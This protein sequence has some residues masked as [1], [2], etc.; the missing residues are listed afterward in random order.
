MDFTGTGKRLAAN[1][2]GDAA[3]LL[4]VETA[5]LLAFL[6]VEAAGRGFDN[7]ARPKMLRETHIFYRELGAGA[8]RDRAV[9]LGLATKSWTRNYT[10]DSYPDLARMMAIDT[11]AALRSCSWGL[12]Q[13]M[14]FNHAAAGFSTVE[15]MVEAM[16]QGEREQ[17]LAF[18][19]LLRA[20]K[21]AP[22][23]TGK[24]FTKPDSWKQAA[25]KYNGAGYAANGYHTRMAAAYRK[26]KGQTQ[27]PVNN[28]P[29]AK[30][31]D[32]LQFGTK[33]ELVLN[34]QND[35]AA[36]GYVFA[37]GID[38]RFGN[39]TKAH[40]IAFQKSQSLVPDGRVGPETK[41]ALRKAVAALGAIAQPAPPQRPENTTDEP[42]S[43]SGRFWQWITAGGGTAI[44]PMVDWRVQVVIAVAIVGV[45]IY[46]IATMPA[47]RKRI[48][49]MLA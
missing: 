17:L 16:K 48:G 19:N 26:H 10:G 28:A 44:L 46:A 25:Q 1:D 24:D 12:P 30:A 23:L 40:V 32:V 15:A 49:D 22:M 33:G 6:E 5:V 21:M 47:L 9:A 18:V 39:E 4:G 11:R 36:L 42:V 43:K 35:L 34:L 14:G 7:K 2:I 8:K 37:A 45:A 31:G 41:E 3:G 29:V 20:W 27:S 38:G 13:I